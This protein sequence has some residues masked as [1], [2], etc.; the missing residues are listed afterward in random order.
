MTISTVLK[1]KH[2]Y[3]MALSPHAFAIDVED[4]QCQSSL[5]LRVGSFVADIHNNLLTRSNP[6][7]VCLLF[8]G[9]TDY[10]IVGMWVLLLVILAFLRRVLVNNGL[11]RMSTYSWNTLR[12]GYDVDI[13]TSLLYSK[14]QT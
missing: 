8:S 5:L 10:M 4:R 11:W 12:S 13:K 6:S 1:S 3:R 7:I 2:S 9:R 14:R